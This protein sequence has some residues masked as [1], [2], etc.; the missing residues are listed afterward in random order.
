MLRSGLVNPRSARAPIRRRDAYL[1]G[2]A[3]RRGDTRSNAQAL[4]LEGCFS[5]LRPFSANL[6]VL[7][8]ARIQ[9]ALAGGRLAQI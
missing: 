2:P 1:S 7:R 4:R 6:R 9:S 3:R 5:G 8:D